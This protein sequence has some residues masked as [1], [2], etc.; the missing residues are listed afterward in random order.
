ML[1]FVS[2]AWSGRQGGVELDFLTECKA[3][4]LEGSQDTEAVHSTDSSLLNGVLS[5]LTSKRAIQSL[6]VYCAK[7]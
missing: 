7:G 1:A 5:G 6:D 3:L 4:V 2:S